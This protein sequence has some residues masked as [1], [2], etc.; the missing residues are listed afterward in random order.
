MLTFDV[1]SQNIKLVERPSRDLIENQLKFIEVCFNFDSYWDGIVKTIQFRQPTHKILKNIET[2][3]ENQIIVNM[4]ENLKPGVVRISVYG[5]KQNKTGE[6]EDPTTGEIIETYST[7]EKV[8]TNYYSLVIERSGFFGNGNNRL[9]EKPTEVIGD[10]TYIHEQLEAASTWGIKH[11]LGKY[12]SVSVC[13]TT[14]RLV[15]GEVIYVDSNNLIVKFSSA[16]T[17]YA[18][19]N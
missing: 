4:P 8:E 15:Q 1:Q 18:Y 3:S 11:K 16:F 2:G 14:G 5:K 17:G 19:L 9:N 10:K 7:D 6:I 12:P 13:D